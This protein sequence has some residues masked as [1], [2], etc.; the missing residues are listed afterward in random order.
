MN[1][2]SLKEEKFFFHICVV[3]SLFNFSVYLKVYLAF[4][5]NR[6]QIIVSLRSSIYLRILV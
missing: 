4:S 5:K 2:K 6:N 3:V 1:G